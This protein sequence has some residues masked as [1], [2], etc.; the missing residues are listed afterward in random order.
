MARSRIPGMDLSGPF[1]QSDPAKTF[2]RNIR[3]FMDEVVE[4]GAEDVRV[5]LRAGQGSRAAISA[6]GERVADYV[7]GRTSNLSGKRWAVT[8]VVSVRPVGLSRRGAIS[9]MAAAARVEAQT[10]A[11]RRTTSRL[12]KAKTDLLKG[13]T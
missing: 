1:F 9:V 7:V 4:V 5:Q 8:G 11:F 10:H 13:L 6:T 12:R 3:D 2:R